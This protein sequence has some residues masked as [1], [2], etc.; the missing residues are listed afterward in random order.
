MIYV[1]LEIESDDDNTESSPASKVSNP[2]R[3]NRLRAA[4]PD[5]RQL[6]F[7]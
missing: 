2:S 7:G 6:G 4:F 1:P 3:D 5:I